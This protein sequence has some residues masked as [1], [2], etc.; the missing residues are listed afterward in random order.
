MG[1]ACPCA[2][3]V[4]VWNRLEA[5]SLTCMVPCLGCLKDEVHVGLLTT[6]AARRILHQALGFH[7]MSAGFP[8]EAS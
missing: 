5:P 4:A 8:E 7:S 6:T 3:V 2:A 1:I